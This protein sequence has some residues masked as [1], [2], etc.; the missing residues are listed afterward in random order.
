L[1]VSLQRESPAL[2]EAIRYDIDVAGRHTR[3]WI[4]E[5]IV[6]DALDLMRQRNVVSGERVYA[7]PEV[8]RFIWK[9]LQ[10]R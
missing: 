4:D 1:P 3:E 9:Q 6:T 5:W 10:V 2:Q 7:A 8:V